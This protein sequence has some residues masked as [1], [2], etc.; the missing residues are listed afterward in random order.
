MFKANIYNSKLL[1]KLLVTLLLIPFALQATVIEW[2]LQN[3]YGISQSGFASVILDAKSHFVVSGQENDTI[4][5]RID[6]G[7]YN[8]GGNGSHGIDFGNGLNN[9]SQNN[10]GRLI[11]QGA[12]MDLT[13]LVF[14]E[15]EQ[16]IVRGQNVYRL[17]FRDMHMTR[18]RYTVSQGTVVSVAPGEIVLDI[19]P[20]FPHPTMEGLIQDWGQGRYLRKYTKSKTDPQII[21][22]NNN[23]VAWGWRNGA[24]FLPEQ[25]S[26]DRWRIYLNNSNQLLNNYNVGDYIGIKSKKA[27][28]IYWFAGGD[29]LVF[30]NIKW[31]HC[32]RG[33]VRSGF[34]NV[35]LYGCRIERAPAINGQTPCLSTSEG[36][37]QMNQYESTGN[38]VSTNMVVEDCF[39]DS[40]GDD[41]IAFFNVNGGIVRNSSLRNSFA[42]GILAVQEA[43]NICIVN[44]IVE[45]SVISY[46]E[47]WSYFNVTDAIAAVGPF[48]KDCE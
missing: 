32:S 4:I 41:C 2:N 44:T 1:K 8:I 39:I 43:Q 29:D 33:L 13:K 34:S 20:G 11:F 16:D 23:Q 6:A 17:E 37:P 38:S 40:T 36:G 31:T 18:D 35:R 46:E 5:V 28:H 10:L 30:R 21:Q 19:E 47:T 12:G 24:L 42:R 27:G 14:T 15:I 9:N 22:N 26:G 3:L 7:T 45:N 25:I 48:N